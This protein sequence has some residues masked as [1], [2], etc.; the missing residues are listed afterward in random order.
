RDVSGLEEVKEQ[1]RL[2]LIYPFSH[3]AEA[4]RYG[5]RSGGGILLYGPPGT[6]KT[7]IAR[8]TAGELDASFFTAKPSELMSKWVGEAEQNI[9]RLFTAARACPR[10]VIFLD[11]VDALLPARRGSNSSVMQRV[12]PQFLAELEGFGGRSETLLFIGA[13]NEPWSIDPAALRPGRFDEKIY[14]PLPDAAARR[15]ILEL[16]LDSRPLAADVDLDTLTVQLAG[17]S[18]ADIVQTCL[19]ASTSA[20]LDAVEQAVM[21]NI[22]CNDFEEALAAVRPSVTSKDL[23]RYERFSQGTN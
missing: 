23:Q 6:G 7:L 14:V 5:I 21:R 17:Y 13:T 18:G 3:P 11:E 19:R 16:N 12:V 8:A 20:F 1:I 2:K 15:R 4:E 22:G 9:Q 10:A